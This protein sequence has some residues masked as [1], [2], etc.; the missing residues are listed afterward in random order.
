MPDVKESKQFIGSLIASACYHTVKDI[1]P[2]S[3]LIF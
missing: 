1:S 2:Q 3:G